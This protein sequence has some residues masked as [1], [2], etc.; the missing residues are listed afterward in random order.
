MWNP[1][2]TEE[3]VTNSPEIALIQDAADSP[4][5]LTPEPFFPRTNLQSQQVPKD[6]VKSVIYVDVFKI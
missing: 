5:H 2:F 6:E 1:A 4:K 3:T